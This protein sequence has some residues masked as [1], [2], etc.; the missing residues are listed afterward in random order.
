VSHH[1]FHVP[2]MG[3]GFTID[4]PLRLAPLG[5]DSVV[6]VVD[7]DL[8]E[9]IRQY[10]ASAYNRT[11]EAI[12]RR[13]PDSRAR[14]IRSYLDLLNELVHERFHELKQQAL[15]DS[16]EKRRYFELLPENHPL[17][18]AY[19]QLMARATGSGRQPGEEALDAAMRPGSIDVNI[20]SKLDAAPRGRHADETGPEFSDALTALRGFAESSV[21]GCLVISAGINKKLFRYATQFKQLYR[22]AEGDLRKKLVLKVSNFRSA[23]IQGKFLA[24]L[25]LEV[26]EYRLESGLNCGGHAFGSQGRIIPLLL[27]EF[28]EKRQE[29]C[30]RLAPLVRGFYEKNEMP[31]PED[32]LSESKITVQGGVG[33]HGEQLRLMEDYGVDSVG[34]ASPFLL[35]P[36]ATR[37]DAET[38]QQLARAGRDDLYLSKA[39]PLGI[40]FNNLKNSS[41]ERWTVERQDAGK[42]GSPCPKGFLVSSTE[43]GDKPLCTASS[44]YQKKRLEKL[45]SSP[46]DGGLCREDLLCKACICDHLGNGA[47]VELELQPAEKAPT[48]VCP[49]PNIAWFNREYTLDEMVDHIYGRT[50]LTESQRPHMFIAELEMNVKQFAELLDGGCMSMVEERLWR[51]N[52]AEGLACCKDLLMGEARVGENMQSL[53][54][55]VQRIRH[56][57]DEL[58]KVEEE[59]HAARA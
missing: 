13:D 35:V 45:E 59:V 58:E 19:R 32:G 1:H 53:H 52:L 37:L 41:S 36:E 57:L 11:V 24:G 50:H 34:W 56:Q 54:A 5:I 21:N 7:D 18:E 9:E 12:H 3:T 40:P 39:S 46:E 47:L 27:E 44:G 43:F 2:V 30:D 28:R 15:C 8:I 49:G 20:M 25:G 10:V 42:P 16:P 48:A 22:D 14:R 31:C 33:V 17:R 51:Q 26:H 23:L 55:G 4:S 6:S 29:L 38:R